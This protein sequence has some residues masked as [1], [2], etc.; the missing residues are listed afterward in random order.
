VDYVCLR[1]DG[2][3][4]NSRI[5]ERKL[6]LL[7]M[8]GVRADGRKELAATSA[9]DFAVAPRPRTIAHVAQEEDGQA[10]TAPS[11]LLSCGGRSHRNH[12]TTQKAGFSKAS[13]SHD[14]A[15]TTR[16]PNQAV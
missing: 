2:I 9:A 1:A 8:I 11:L 16:Q 15:T 3:H 5:E 14:L 13:S 12:R 7:V 10:F 4:V 6:C